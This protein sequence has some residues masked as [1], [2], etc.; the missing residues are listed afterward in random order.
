MSKLIFE[1]NDGVTED[2]TEFDFAVSD[3]TNNK[4]LT[5]QD[6][7]EN[8]DWSGSGFIIFIAMDKT[9]PE[10]LQHNVFFSD[11]YENEYI[12]IYEKK[13]PSDDMTIYVS[14][15][16][17]HEKDDCPDGTENWFIF[18]N[19]PHLSDKFIWNE[20]S[21]KQY[22]DKVISRL[23]SF[24]LIF[25]D[26]PRN[27]IRFYEVFT[28]EDFKEKYNCEYGSIYGLSSNSLYTLI[29]RPKNKSEKYSN[30]FFT[31]GNTN[32]GGGVPL[33]FLSGKMVSEMI[34]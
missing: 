21:S 26:S 33:C 30:L 24:N 13:I 15:S 10:L 28:P 16:G 25:D 1:K 9:F 6:Y 29:K 20:N 4:S 31:G 23:E 11:D 18:V 12:D 7:F 14:I 22:F 3:F 34:N 27:H 8:T 17:K 2:V 19:A 5:G 32:P